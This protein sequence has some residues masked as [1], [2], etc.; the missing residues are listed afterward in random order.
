MGRVQF[1]W[2]PFFPIEIWQSWGVSFVSTGQ[3]LML[4]TCQRSL[5]EFFQEWEWV[6][7][8]RNLC[9]TWSRYLMVL[10]ENVVTFQ[11][12]RT[13]VLK[14]SALSAFETLFPPLAVLFGKPRRDQ[15]NLEL[16]EN[17]PSCGK[18]RPAATVAAR[19]LHELR[20]KLGYNG[21]PS[22]HWRASFEPWKIE[23]LGWFQDDFWPLQ[24]EGQLVVQHKLTNV[25]KCSIQGSSM[26][27]SVW[28]F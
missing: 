19:T 15:R 22:I 4:Q 14:L 16:A 20:A 1:R 12:F 28:E 24:N 18:T 17:H 9:V 13:F 11:I 7:R 6:A 25:S 26:V 5:T 21:S 27:V 8:Q 3:C 10:H 23:S 2:Q